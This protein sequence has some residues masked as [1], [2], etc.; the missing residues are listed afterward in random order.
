MSPHEL[1]ERTEFQE[2]D[3][4]FFI[5]KLRERVGSSNAGCARDVPNLCVT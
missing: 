5:F 4:T 2:P 1:F 3:A